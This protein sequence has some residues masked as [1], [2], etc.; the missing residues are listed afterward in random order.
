M[1]SDLD[2]C[3]ERIN[4]SNIDLMI[5]QNNEFVT[6]LKKVVKLKKL[7]GNF[8][9][10]SPSFTNYYIDNV[11]IQKYITD[12]NGFFSKYTDLNPLQNEEANKNIRMFVAKMSLQSL[13]DMRDTYVD[14]RNALKCYLLSKCEI[15]VV[16]M[17]DRKKSLISLYVF[18]LVEDK[19]Q[20]QYYTVKNIYYM[21][22]IFCR[23]SPEICY[24]ST[25]LH[26]YS[27]KLFG[28][29]LW[30]S[31]LSS[32]MIKILEEREI[33]FEIVSELKNTNYTSQVCIKYNCQVLFMTG[34]KNKIYCVHDDKLID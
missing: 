28:N 15:Y 3:H 23:K 12:I 30:I 34:N 7:L 13:K 17:K 32:E 21:F 11:N 2:Y 14:R 20:I 8:S 26:L 19:I 18:D 22:E 6:L 4:E 31:D 1:L 9:N 10:Q 24:L 33:C 29:I 16:S 5:I 25:Y 27:S